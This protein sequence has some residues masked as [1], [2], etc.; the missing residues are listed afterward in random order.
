MT[1]GETKNSV[2]CSGVDGKEMKKESLQGLHVDLL[3]GR[4]APDFFLTT[5]EHC[6]VSACPRQLWFRV[7]GSGSN[8]QAVAHFRLWCERVWP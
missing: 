5:Q 8:H 4:E 2:A 7:R 3:P 6:K 1:P